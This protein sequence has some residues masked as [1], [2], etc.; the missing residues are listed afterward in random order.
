LIKDGETIVIG[1]LLK[2]V[3][4]KE[5]IG[6]PF[7]SKIPLIGALFRR[8]TDDVAKIDLLIFITGRIM[9]ENELTSRDIAKLEERLDA[10]DVVVVNNDSKADKNK[11][12]PKSKVKTTNKNKK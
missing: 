8:E 2:D 4:S 11:A 5:T 9:K 12:K 10:E 3:K 1:G 6:I 7:L